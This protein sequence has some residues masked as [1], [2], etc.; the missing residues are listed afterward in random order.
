L[1][2]RWSH[3]DPYLQNFSYLPTWSD[4]ATRG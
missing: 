3:H 1:P 2:F 4:T